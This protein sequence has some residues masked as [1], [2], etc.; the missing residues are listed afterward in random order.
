MAED[1]IWVGHCAYEDF[2]RINLR[3]E[4]QVQTMAEDWPED[5][6]FFV[7]PLTF[8]DTTG[9]IETTN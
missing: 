6:Y 4:S 9:N 1:L 7:E 2:V 8:V 3:K 5:I